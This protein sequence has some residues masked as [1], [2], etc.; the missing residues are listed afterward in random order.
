[1]HVENVCDNII[2]TLLNIPDKTK[3]NVKSILD[4][5]EMRLRKQLAPKK[6]RQN[7]YILSICYTMSR[8]K[9]IKLCLYLTR[10]KVP[11]GYSSNI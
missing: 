4:M 11:S 2:G 5:V 6:R 7:T 1:M 10:I 9:K 8:K 3:D